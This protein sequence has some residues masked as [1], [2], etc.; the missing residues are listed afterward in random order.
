M[1]QLSDADITAL[2]LTAKLAGAT[3]IILLLVCLPLAWL[4]S[5]SRSKVV[6]IF[7]ALFAMPLV[8]PPTV[9]GFYL[10]VLFSPNTWLGQFWFSVT[11]SQLA[12]SFAG[13]LL[14]SVIYS[15]PFVLQPL[16]QTFLNMDKSVIE[17]ARGLKTPAIDL[18]RKIIWPMIRP[19]VITA[20]TLGFAHTLGE[21]GVVL[22]IGGNI[23]GETQVVSIALYDHVE[24]LEFAKAHQLSAV[25]IVVSLLILIASYWNQK[26][27][28]S[29]F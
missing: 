4:L 10:L 17:V 25:L 12:F 5:R 18:L 21:F 3:T 14:G 23:S 7:D 16:K 22:M 1:W 19:G 26:R 13:V 15:L 2:I 27:H 8:L 20:A 24:A 11:G 6:V 28:A 29:V 9:L